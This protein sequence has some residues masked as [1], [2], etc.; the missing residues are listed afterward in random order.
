MFTSLGLPPSFFFKKTILEVGPGGGYNSLAYFKWGASVDLVEPNP[1][2]QEELAELLPKHNIKKKRW[3]L[4]TCPIEKF[5]STK[6]YDLIIAEGFIPGLHSRTGVISKISE[7]VNPGGVIVVTCID[8]ISWFFDI[9]QRVIGLYLLQTKNITGFRAKV[10]ALSKA[11]QSHLRSLKHASRLLEDWVIDQFFT[12]SIN[13]QCFSMGECIKEFGETFAFL[14]SSPSMFTDYSWYKNTSLDRHDMLL[15]QFEKKRHILIYYHLNESIRTAKSNAEL[16]IITRKFRMLVGKT[17]NN[18]NR[19]N[20][21]EI[22]DTLRQISEMTSD[23]DRRI[24]IAINEGI[25]LL[26]DDNIDEKKISNADRV[27]NAFG[28][29]QQYVSMKKIF[30]DCS[31]NSIVRSF[32]ER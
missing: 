30:T 18:L 9:L 15:R 12:P 1:K 22:I 16:A 32:K 27:A 8:D 2:A 6:T 29:C 17:E 24:P 28:K 20:I 25:E 4:S 13:A 26:S 10:K 3:S 5:A 14:G 23:V 21:A 7:L 31:I 19:H 11:F